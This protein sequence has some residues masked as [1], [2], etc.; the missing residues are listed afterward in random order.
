MTLPITL[1]AQ[2]HAN[3]RGIDLKKRTQHIT[4]RKRNAYIASAPIGNARWQVN[5]VQS[6]LYVVGIGL[7][8]C[9][10]FKSKQQ[11]GADKH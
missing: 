11:A 7:P 5:V 10:Q 1:P 8:G 9:S 2:L 3:A 4:S 6:A